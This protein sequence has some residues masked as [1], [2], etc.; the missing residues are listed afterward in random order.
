MRFALVCIDHEKDGLVDGAWMQNF[1][2]TLEEASQWARETEK[3]NSNRISVAVVEDMYYTPFSNVYGA[4]RLD[5]A[6][7]RKADDEKTPLPGPRTQSLEEFLGERGLSSPASDFLL[8]KMR[9]PH[10]LTQRQRKAFEK[11][12][13]AAG[14]LYAEKRQAAV[15]EYNRLLEEGKI[16][17]PTK[18]ERLLKVARGHEDNEATHAAR[19][20]LE[21]RG[22]DW[23][24]GTAGKD[25]HMNNEKNKDSKNTPWEKYNVSYE[26]DGVYQAILVKAPS[27]EVAGTYF[28]LQ[29]PGATLCGV[30]EATRD[31]ERPG[32]PEL[33]AKLYEVWKDCELGQTYKVKS[34]LDQ[35]NADDWMAKYEPCYP[36]WHLRVVAVE[37]KK[38]CLDDRIQAASQRAEND[39]SRTAE[40]DKPFEVRGDR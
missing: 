6:P 39:R 12:A 29:E 32:K 20:A 8:D 7:E 26:R 38:P 5:R 28:Q 17:S 3:A 30:K 27:A 35:T 31:D 16:Q 1:T 11:E 15:D 19:R 24:F 10:G 4:K 21:K 22:I 25:I 23:R 33:T 37:E 2:G 14:R 9:F 13:E 36:G 40:K 34:F 18:E